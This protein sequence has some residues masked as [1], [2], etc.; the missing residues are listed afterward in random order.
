MCTNLLICRSIREEGPEFGSLDDLEDE[1][2]LVIDQEQWQGLTTVHIKTYTSRI[3]K[4]DWLL[5]RIP[6]YEASKIELLLDDITISYHYFFT[7]LL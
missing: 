6:Y 3:L 1:E 2:P 4:H 5:V 7:V